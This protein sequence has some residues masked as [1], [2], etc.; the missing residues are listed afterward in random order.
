MCNITNYILAIRQS[1]SDEEFEVKRLESLTILSDALR[2]L[3][4]I[5]LEF[6]DFLN[7]N[8]NAFLR[9]TLDLRFRKVYLAI[10]LWTHL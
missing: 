8:E 7:Q 10:Y 5:E 1:S 3:R 6:G 2:N 9:A 4:L